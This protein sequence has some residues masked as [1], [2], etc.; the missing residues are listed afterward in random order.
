MGE[1]INKSTLATDV[2]NDIFKLF[3]WHLHPKKD[4]NFGCCKS[5]DHFAPRKNSKAATTDAPQQKHHPTDAVFDYL[6]PYLE[7]RTYLLTDFK[8]YSAATLKTTNIRAALSSLSRTIDCAD[9][10]SEWRGR[11]VIE[12]DPSDIRGLL[13]VYNH[14]GADNGAF[15]QK[16]GETNLANLPLPDGRLIH[17]IGP[18]RISGLLSIVADMSALTM[19]KDL[20]QEYTFLYPDL[21]AWKRRGDVW[22]QPATV[23]ALT[24]PYLIIK[25]RKTSATHADGYV[26]YYHGAGKSYREFIY[27]ID[28][29]SRFQVLTDKL[30]ILIRMVAPEKGADY[31]NN[32]EIA[33]NRYIVGWSMDQSR[34]DELDLITIG[35]IQWVVPAYSALEA[36][37][38][39]TP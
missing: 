11:Y 5:Q 2:S 39:Q 4:E 7:K 9:V 28:T 27:L 23:E 38:R 18:A 37:W 3:K 35:A 19:K 36:G 12:D 25:H 29:L 33:K 16:F 1:T 13:F 15:E 8:S 21:V 6:D 31:Q 17:V 30:P 14:D 32:L 34:R 10:S 22:E 24:A 26:I 20:G